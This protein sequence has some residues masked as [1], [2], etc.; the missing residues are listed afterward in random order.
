[1]YSRFR[2]VLAAVGAVALVVVSSSSAG[3]VSPAP[4]AGGPAGQGICAAQALAARSAGSAAALRTFGDCEIGRRQKTLAG[5]AAVV[6]GSQ[7]MTASDQ[8]AASAEIGAE[9]S[10]LAGLQTAIDG[11]TAIPALRL[12]IVQIASKF[13]VYLLVAPQVHLV[14]AADGVLALRP[15]LTQMA[16]DLAGRIA[17][18]RANG[19]N[20]AAAQADLDAMS[21]EVGAA[22][23]LASPLPG[24]LL[25]L[26]AAAWNAGTAAPVLKTARAALVSAR[27]HLRNAVKYG[28]ALIVALQ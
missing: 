24:K 23:A 4:V 13:R 5:L 17:T 14:N 22:M 10:G 8:A 19:A 2:N 3:A 18:A 15:S 26:T 12:E 16:T 28:R 9:S 6:T 27:D 11:Q 20:V 25:T 7:A 21:S 1:M